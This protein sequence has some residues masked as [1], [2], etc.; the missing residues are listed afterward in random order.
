M[1]TI[2]CVENPG[3]ARIGLVFV[4]WGLAAMVVL[5]ACSG[6]V[7]IRQDDN[8]FAH[9]IE[10]LDRTHHLIASTAAREDE[11]TMFLQAEALYRYRFDPPPRAAGSYLAQAGAVLI[12]LP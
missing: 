6:S 4:R 2:H 9:S 1:A 10:R 12:D 5:P 11:K 7:L 8:T 3:V